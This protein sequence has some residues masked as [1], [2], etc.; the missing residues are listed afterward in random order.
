MSANPT[1]P[2]FTAPGFLGCYRHPERMTGIS[3]QRCGK[4]ICG[5]CM[6]PASVGFQ[7]PSCVHRGRAGTRPA[8]TRFGATVRP[9]SGVVTKALMVVLAGVWLLD[10][11]TGGL[12]TRLLFMDNAAVAAGQVWRLLTASLSSGSFLGVL[13]NLVVLWL[14]GRALESELG[15]WRFLA[16]YLT[17]GLG[18]TTLFFVFGPP[19]GG[20]LAASAA[21]VG[22]LAANAI[23]KRKAGEDVRGDVGLLLLLVLYALL[24]GFSGYGWLTLVGGILVGALSGWVL[25]H[26]P[27]RRRSLLQVTGL[28]GVVALCA[29][30][31]ALRVSLF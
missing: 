15:R 31:V 11:V 22:L 8:R 30:A 26:A 17:A 9:D 25:A 19:F 1:G 13:M 29:V 18:G 7:C 24:V 23:G 5:E 6:E 20:A 27:R 2:D 28:L 21:V 3:C 14:A 16:L 4:P 10:F 12:A